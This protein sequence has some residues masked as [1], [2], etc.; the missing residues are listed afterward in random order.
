MILAAHQPQYLPWLGYFDKIDKADFFVLL[1]TVQYKKNEW[2]NRNKIK[3]AQGGQ[4]FTVPVQYKFPE[5]IFEVAIDNTSRWQ[6]KQQHTLT[7]NYAKAPHFKQISEALADIFSSK[8]ERISLLNIHVVKTLA[9]LLGITTP[10]YIASELGSF[11][12]GPDERLIALARHFKA[13][14][15]LAGAGGKEYMDLSA[16][17]AAGIH[18]EFQTYGHPVYPQ[19]YG[20]FLPF[21]SVIDLL[22][23]CGEKESLSIIRGAYEHPGNRCAS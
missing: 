12:D 22:F 8:W 13:T 21:M 11:P 2:Q 16:Y 23:N 3:T 9:K 14:T 17:E 18:V 6:E 15:Y 4:W 1:D 5:K 7:T 10:I 20:E 19:L